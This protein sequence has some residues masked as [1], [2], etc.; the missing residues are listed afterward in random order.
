[1]DDGTD[2]DAEEDECPPLTMFTT[3]ESRET[4]VEVEGCCCATTVPLPKPVSGDVLLLPLF[5]PLSI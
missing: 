2:D 5:A 3:P 1:M 4:T